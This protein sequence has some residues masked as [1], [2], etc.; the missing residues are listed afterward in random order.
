MNNIYYNTKEFI[1]DMD[2]ELYLI[3]EEF[4]LIIDEVLYAFRYYLMNKEE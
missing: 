1:L 4:I 2:Y 3:K